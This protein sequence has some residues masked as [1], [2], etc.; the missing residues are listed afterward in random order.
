MEAEEIYITEQELK[1][2]WLENADKPL[3]KPFDSFKVE[4]ALLLVDDEEDEILL[5]GG[6]N[7]KQPEENDD[8]EIFVLRSEL[9]RIWAERALISWGMPGKNFSE[10]DALL[11]LDNSED[12]LDE[13]QTEFQNTRQITLASDDADFWA[14]RTDDSLLAE[15][16]KRIYDELE[17]RTYKR[18]A[19][20]KERH[21]LTPGKVDFS[22]AKL[23]RPYMIF[24][25][26]IQ[27]CFKHC[28]VVPN[29]CA[30]QIS[31]LRA[32]WAI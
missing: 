9:E 8:P 11:L 7:V 31:T 24:T 19:W 22:A 17:D 29:N 10:Q 1:R 3:G 14:S 25:N 21:I 12:E 27:I 6:V 28:L 26:M 4:D 20:K 30:H 15:G 32:S 2:L 5:S 13:E 18:P 16:L 23:H